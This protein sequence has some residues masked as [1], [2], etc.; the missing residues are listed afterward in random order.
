MTDV[1]TDPDMLAGAVHGL[2]LA[3][4]AT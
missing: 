1:L 2:F 3:P 4:E